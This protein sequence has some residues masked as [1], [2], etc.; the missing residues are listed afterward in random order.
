MC[1]HYG[2]YGTV[3]FRKHLHTY[4]K[5]YDGANQFRQIINTIT[6]PE[7]MLEEIKKFF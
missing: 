3:M 4:S 7:V 5:G 1:E 6:D 2:E